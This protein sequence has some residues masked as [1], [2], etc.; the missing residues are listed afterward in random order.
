MFRTVKQ[1]VA[2]KI[3]EEGI[4]TSVGFQGRYNTVTVPAVKE[5]AKNNVIPYVN[6]GRIS[7]WTS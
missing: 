6:I 2:K 7:N 3:K 4:I 5:F 1:A